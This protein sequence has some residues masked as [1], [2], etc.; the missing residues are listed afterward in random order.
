MIYITLAKGK[1]QIKLF[2][3]DIKRVFKLVKRVN[4]SIPVFKV[5]RHVN[6]STDA[7]IEKNIELE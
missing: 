5:K 4:I 2:I 3:N 7:D 1:S 6:S